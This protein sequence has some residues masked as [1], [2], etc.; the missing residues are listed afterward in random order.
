M[1]PNPE[2]NIAPPITPNHTASHPHMLHLHTY[3]HTY[4]CC[5]ALLYFFVNG[6][7]DFTPFVHVGLDVE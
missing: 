2:T 3:M 4:V 1:P 7:I 5:N 6:K